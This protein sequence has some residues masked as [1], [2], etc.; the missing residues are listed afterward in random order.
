MKILFVHQNFPGQFLHVA[1]ALARRGHDV[2]ALTASTNQRRFS[3]NSARYQISDRKFPKETFGMAAHFAEK[4]ARGMDVALAAAQLK[5]S[6]YEPDIIFS[7][8]GWG[9]GLFLKEVWPK[10]KKIVYA[11]FFYAP[12][13]RDTN[14]EPEFQKD[15]LATSVW[16]RARTA[17]MALDMSDADYALAPTQWQAST[18]PGEHQARLKVIH[19]GVR[20][21]L[22]TP[23]PNATLAMPE[24][25]LTL[26]SGDEILTFVSRNL[27]PYR[28]YHILMR[29]L[30]KIL[31]ARPNAQVVIVG[32]DGFSYGTRPPGAQS[33][34]EMFLNEVKDQIDQSRVHFLGYVDYNR[35]TSVIRISRV[36]AY[37]TY[38]FVLSW[39]MLE[40]MSAGALVVGSR[41]PPV[42]EAITHGR[43]GLLV[44]FFDVAGWSEAIIDALA[45]PEHYKGIRAAARETVIQRY[46]VNS[47][48]LPQM[49]SF[50]ESV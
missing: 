20:T 13:G 19:D 33:W 21:E 23:D 7:H 11:E 26:R 1:P 42:Q 41:T 17:A 25:N 29:S 44:D 18:F 22:L 15:S 14:F 30:P 16:V 35:F 31:K 10:A 5:R 38:P 47:V 28:G 39:S 45:R 8:I 50:L 49:I 40:A 34:K 4:S 6:G 9:E 3:V 43:N 37:L 12:Y 46:D 27:E 32:G 24:K 48:C 36:H 2:L